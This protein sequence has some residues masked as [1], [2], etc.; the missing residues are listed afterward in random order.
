MENFIK[1]PGFTTGWTPI[2]TRP[3]VSPDGYFSMREWQ[4]DCY[5]SFEGA[6]HWI[7]NTP[8]ASG[9]SFEICCLALRE[10]KNNTKLKVIIAVPQTIIA[11]S[12][13]HNRIELP[14]GTKHDW[15]VQYNLCR[16]QTESNKLYLQSFLMSEGSAD[17]VQ[18][19]VIVCTHATL[20]AGYREYPELF[21]DI[22]VVIDEAHHVSNSELEIED[23]EDTEED[24]AITNGIGS[25]VQ[26]S[27]D[28]PQFNIRLGLTTA[29]FFRGDRTAII[30][31]K[32][33]DLFKRYNLPYDK[34]L[35]TCKHLKSFSY[36]FLL[37]NEKYT[38]ALNEVFKDSVGKSIVYIPA[39]GG[40]YTL[41]GKHNDVQMVYNAI[42]GVEN[43]EVKLEGDAIVLVKRGEEWVR[44]VNLVD[45]TNREAKKKLV[46]LAHKDKNLVDVIIALGMFKEGA[47]WQ[48]ADREVI[49]G[50]KNS[51]TDIVQIVGRLFRDVDGKET[52]QVYHLL[53]FYIKSLEKEEIKDNLNDYLKA[54]FLS[55]LLE[56]LVNPIRIKSPKK[57]DDGEHDE[58]DEQ[59]IYD[60]EGDDSLADTVPDDTKRR[61]ILDRIK[62][63]ILEAVDI[64]KPDKK[65]L[66]TVFNRI[67]G[68]VLAEEGIE[69]QQE[70][71][72]KQ[73][74]AMWMRRSLRLSGIDVKDINYD[75]I[76]EVSAID[77][78]LSYTSQTCN[79]NTFRELRA[80]SQSRYFAPFEEARE[81]VR[82]FN[83]QSMQEYLDWL[84][85]D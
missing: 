23:E 40:R 21:R 8:M 57:K 17:M 4:E 77:F 79:V 39:A 42:A 58:D 73:I 31:E 7:L 63:G 55:M 26:Y 64:E 29:T 85:E 6:D 34:F 28:N 44:V 22:M 80:A 5:N 78:L 30:P 54:I 74:W 27:F 70:E 61:K 51:L 33:F 53:P 16:E 46:N 60:D 68:E 38:E 49:I 3:T 56:E 59:P 71:I 14:D 72:S 48:Y 37:Y 83:F 75:I 69:E 2:L 11:D 15:F 62:D 45:E 65:E 41:G 1:K 47:N 24:I 66:H 18:D 12:F 67:V 25:L 20:V 36:D 50:P 32:Y 13:L 19:R 9:K 76:D 81:Y 10:L 35:A 84:D 52:V 82:S 43:P